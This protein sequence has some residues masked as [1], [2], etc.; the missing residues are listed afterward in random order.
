MVRLILDSSTGGY[1]VLIGT[2]LQR[3]LRNVVTPINGIEDGSDIRTSF[4]LV[5][6]RRAVY[7]MV[8]K[9]ADASTLA[10]VH[11]V[12]AALPH[13]QVTVRVIKGGLDVPDEAVG[14]V[15]IIASA[16]VTVRL[17]LA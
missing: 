10:V 7:M 3:D 14:D 12:K 4:A 1:P 5:N 6:G 8:S 13:G 2:N 16:A 9:R 17:D 11:R 15:A